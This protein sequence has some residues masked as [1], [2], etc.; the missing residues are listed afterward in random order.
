MRIICLMV[1][2]NHKMVREMSGK[3]QGILWGLMAGHPALG[4]ETMFFNVIIIHWGHIQFVCQI[5]ANQ[6]N[7]WWLVKWFLRSK[8]STKSV[9]NFMQF[10]A[11]NTIS[12][13]SDICHI[14][15][16]SPM[17]VVG[18]SPVMLS[19][20]S[21]PGARC[22]PGHQPVITHLRSQVRPQLSMVCTNKWLNEIFM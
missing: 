15:Y 10:F 14:Y 18:R 7:H 4:N 6:R 5:Y 12:N 9:I 1:R 2:E 11:H 19:N 13:V 16:G 3:S 22:G 8:T 17:S 20:S 21:W